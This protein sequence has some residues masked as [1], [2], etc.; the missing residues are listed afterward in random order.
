MF[1]SLWMSAPRS[2]RTVVSLPE[3]C[4][5][6]TED[7]CLVTDVELSPPI[8]SLTCYLWTV[9]PCTP[10]PD[11]SS[12]L[13]STR[14][15]CVNIG[16]AVCMKTECVAKLMFVY[17]QSGRN[18]GP[19]I[20]EREEDFVRPCRMQSIVQASLQPWIPWHWMK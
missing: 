19:L 6:A 1:I 3:P 18:C 16:A 8:S 13:G 9:L 15:C 12:L 2:E 20:C 17:F 4:A 11:D 10:R 5:M 7:L 14:S